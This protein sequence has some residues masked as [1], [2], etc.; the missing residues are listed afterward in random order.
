M[1]LTSFRIE[2]PSDSPS[3]LQSAVTAT[4]MA[5]N[6]AAFGWGLVNPITLLTIM[7]RMNRNFARAWCMV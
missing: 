6:M 5:A 4:A 1:V 7:V 2:A 3:L